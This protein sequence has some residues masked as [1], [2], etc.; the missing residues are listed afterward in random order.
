MWRDL[1][2]V[3]LIAELGQQR[4]RG[5]VAGVRRQ[6]LNGLDAGRG[7]VGKSGWGPGGW[8]HSVSQEF[9][10]GR[11][12]Q[13]GH[14]L[15]E[16]GSSEGGWIRVCAGGGACLGFRRGR[17]GLG[18]LSHLPALTGTSPAASSGAPAAAATSD[19]LAQS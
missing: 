1:E 7:V 14:L 10:G 8:H 13:V 6:S 4:F 16:K 12:G 19:A 3:G 15:L 17:R 18:G 5:A 9:R 11:G 2:V